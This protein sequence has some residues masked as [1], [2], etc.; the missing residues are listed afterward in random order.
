M[1][2]LPIPTASLRSKNELYTN[3]AEQLRSLV[4]GEAD[5]IANAANLSSLLYHA[6][7]DLNWA[8]FYL[9]KGDELVAWSVS[10][11]TGVC[12][13]CDGQRSLRH[14]GGAATNHH[15]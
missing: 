7:P 10:G 12:A 8:G 3:L 9:N 11:K 4:A 6:L 1:S 2:V 13:H 5:F 14:G 15:R